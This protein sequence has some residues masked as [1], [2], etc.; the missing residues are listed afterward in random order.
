MSFLIVWGPLVG[1]LKDKSNLIPAIS[2]CLWQK[3]LSVIVVCMLSK[4]TLVT[5]IN[6]R[7]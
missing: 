3:S 1:N 5:Y 4:I 7:F 6:I 2:L